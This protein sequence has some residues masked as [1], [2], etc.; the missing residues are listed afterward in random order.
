MRART[1]LLVPAFLFASVALDAPSARAA[2]EVSGT[3]ASSTAWTAADAPYLITGDLTVGPD[4]TLTIDAGVAV[5]IASTKSITISGALDVSGTTDAPV[6]FTS[7]ADDTVGGDTNGDGDMT[8]ASDTPWGQVRI[9]A[10]ATARFMHADLRYGGMPPVRAPGGGGATFIPPLDGVIE[11]S[12]TL[13]FDDS[14]IEQGVFS[15]GIYSDGTLDFSHSAVHD[16][17]TGVALDIYGTATIA[18]SAFGAG[19]DINA[20]ADMVS[21]VSADLTFSDTAVADPV[22]LSDSVVHDGG[23]NTAPLVLDWFSLAAGSTFPAFPFVNTGSDVTVDPGETLTVASGAM[24]KFSGNIDVFGTLVAGSADTDATTTFTSV[25]D[26]SGGVPMPGD[27]QGILAEEGSS[28]RM[29]HVVMAYAGSPEQCG[30]SV[31]YGQ[32]TNMGGDVTISDSVF[33]TSTYSQIM[34][35]DG[36][37]T[38]ERSEV[39]GGSLFAQV[40]GGSLS[41]HGS[42]ITG[43]ADGI[44]NDTSADVD[45]T[46]NWW[47]AASGPRN[48]DANPDGTGA[49]VSAHV[50]FDPWLAADPFAAPPAPRISNVMFLPGIEGSRLYEGTGCGKPSEEMLWEPVEGAGQDA[51]LGV[52]LGAGDAKVA[53]LAL[54]A[55][56]ESVCPD[57][58][59]KADDIIG[60]AGGSNVYA[61]IMSE[62][63][64]LKQDGTIRDWEPVAYDWR[65]SLDDLLAKGS[66]HDGKIYYD[67][68]TSTP[69]IEQTLR[70]LAASS[71]TGK[72]TIIAHSNGGLLAKALLRKLGDA[73]A[74]R[75]VDKVILVAAPQSGAP[76]DVGSLLVG[77]GAGL[78]SNI[79]KLENVITVV[80][81]KAARVFTQDSP[82]AYHLLPSEEYLEST[83]GDPARRVVN[84]SGDA[85]AKEEAAYGS[86]IANISALDDFLLAKDGGRSQADDADLLSAKIL[87]PSLIDYANSEHSSLDAWAP[88]PGI[89]VDQIAGWG[90]DTV[91]GIDF[92]TVPGQALSAVAASPARMYRPL[93]VE[94]G[95]GTVTTPSALM[96]A[97]STQVKRY[98]LNLDSY[99]VATSVQRKHGDIFEVPQLRDFIKDLVENSASIP[100]AYISENQP[101]PIKEVKKLTFFLHSPLTLQLTDSSGAVTGIAS[102]GTVSENIPGST[103]GEFG[104]V[105]YVSVP[106]GGSYD[107]LMRGQGSGTFS[108][109]LQESTGGAV[110]TTSSFADVPVTESTLASLSIS[111]GVDTASPLAVD[112]QG[113][114]KNVITLTPEAGE[115]V[116]YAPAAPVPAA[117]GARKSEPVSPGSISIPAVSAVMRSDP[118]PSTPPSPSA[119]TLS[120]A[121]TLAAAVS[122]LPHVATTSAA[123]A[124]GTRAAIAFEQKPTAR[125]LSA[126][127][128]SAPATNAQGGEAAARPG[129]SAVAAVALA[130]SVQPLLTQIVGS[131][132]TGL[133]ML[134]SA[135]AHFL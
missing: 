92:Y 129:E 43:T 62:M 3:I 89:T 52:V 23:G 25:T 120:L 13:A 44:R 1:L 67:E 14:T 80:S 4:A 99:K 81:N 10:G 135:L 116:Q 76:S 64:G 46:G 48:A 18:Q 87:N 100:P 70:S 31:C 6:T 103:Y 110:T 133:H 119:A 90:V 50:L 15:G 132:Y 131:L 59:T 49:S 82:M 8:V 57:I 79:G 38:V 32:L 74:A 19:E 41:V 56:G 47:G 26:G 58:Y 69:Y 122:A 73:E 77:Y 29:H 83:M 118:L 84:F 20:D 115:T 7:N 85:Y 39:L 34:Q 94:D 102:D 107:L 130:A 112:E 98:W 95:D 33:A 60:A 117:A 51:L 125:R 134:W 27:W 11:N 12:G 106:E 61:S 126:S 28:V 104:E 24:V 30:Y 113:D 111:N 55:S 2:T 78:Y 65:L 96:M 121:T 42:S 36:T 21:G 97:S 123:A 128:P 124:S 5:K 101:L 17:Y 68:A 91:A 40:N 63:D 9:A 88:P 72:V 35:E 45:A 75:L 127:A 22:T 71:A 105:K 114:G 109:D 16:T 93:F 37:T 86:T 54:D 53:Q 108:L 66:E